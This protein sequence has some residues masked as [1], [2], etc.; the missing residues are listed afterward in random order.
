M[1]QLVVQHDALQ[2]A[3]LV[4]AEGARTVGKGAYADW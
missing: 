2:M 4:D 1:F 3:Q